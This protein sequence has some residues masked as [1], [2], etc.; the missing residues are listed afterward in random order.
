MQC[1]VVCSYQMLLL[2]VSMVHAHA[3]AKRRSAASGFPAIY[4]SVGRTR[5]R[6]YGHVTERSCGRITIFRMIVK[7]NE[8]RETERER[9]RNQERFFRVERAITAARRRRRRCVWMCACAGVT[10]AMFVR[11]LAV[12]RRARRS[13]APL[14][15][16][17]RRRRRHPTRKY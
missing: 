14:R 6:V 9:E 8:R 4:L 15:R 10:R 2:R 5:S 12:R 7:R 16:R 13:P 1:G 3:P 11:R 17:R